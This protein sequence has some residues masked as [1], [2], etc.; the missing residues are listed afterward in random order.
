MRRITQ[1]LRP[2]AAATTFGGAVPEY[3]APASGFL[4]I[5]STTYVDPVG[6]Y[7]LDRPPDGAATLIVNDTDHPITIITE[8]DRSAD[9]VLAPGTRTE[10]RRGQAVRVG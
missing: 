9:I 7:P 2:L 6:S 4:T 10:T 3:A 5:G 1:L 8:S